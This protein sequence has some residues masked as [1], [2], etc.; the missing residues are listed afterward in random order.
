MELLLA[1]PAAGAVG[2]TE[3]AVT[4]QRTRTPGWACWRPAVASLPSFPVEA[5]V[6]RSCGNGP[7]ASRQAAAMCMLR[8]KVV[9][10]FMGDDGI[11]GRDRHH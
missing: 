8:A 9:S 6:N 4:H 3:M 1:G 5:L 7:G 11:A 10:Y 2:C